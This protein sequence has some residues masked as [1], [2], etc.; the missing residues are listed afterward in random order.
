MFNTH[1]QPIYN[2]QKDSSFISKQSDCQYK[3]KTHYFN[4]PLSSEYACIRSTKA[5]WFKISATTKFM[6]T[7]F[8]ADYLKVLKYGCCYKVLVFKCRFS[9]TAHRQVIEE[10]FK[11]KLETYSLYIYATF[12]KGP[13][14]KGKQRTAKNKNTLAFRA[15]NRPLAAWKFQQCN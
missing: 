14:E 9:K 12:H 4:S 11:G 10:I 3:Y 15:N 1:Y 8:P 5:I 6:T 2:P 7:N 13:F